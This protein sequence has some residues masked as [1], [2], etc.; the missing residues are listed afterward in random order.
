MA[1][2]CKAALVL[3]GHEEEKQHHG[4]EFGKHIAL[5]WQVRLVS[6]FKTFV[7]VEESSKL[8]Y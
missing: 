2:S 1:K 3:A 6:G 7:R 4:F 8:M 5:A